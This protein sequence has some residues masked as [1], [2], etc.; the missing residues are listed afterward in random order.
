ML[1]EEVKENET[2]VETPEAMAPAPAKEETP[3]VESAPKV[4]KALKTEEV[5]PKA[6]PK[7]ET[8][9]TETAPKEAAPK[10]EHEHAPR[11]EGSHGPRHEGQGHGEA[12]A[13]GTAPE[14][15]PRG[16][17]HH[18]GAP[19]RDQK[20]SEE[21]K[22]FEERTVYI[23]RVAKTVKG[24][25]RMKFTALVVIGNHKGKYG[26]G[27]GKAAEVPDAIK[28]ATESAKKNIHTIPMVKGGTIP[29]EIT[30]HF[31]ASKVY[32]KPAPEG[33]GIIAGG[34][35]RAVLEL[36]GITN[37]CSK[38]YG[39][40]NSINVVKACD[41]GIQHLT[42]YKQVKKLRVHTIETSANEPAPEVS[43][44]AESKSAPKS[45]PKK[46]TE[47]GK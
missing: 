1:E 27:L 23:N 30:G 43:E 11:P 10:T 15:K 25:R 9:K 35:V 33:T 37:V 20:R 45:A 18:K 6:E 44:E 17:A 36:S 47:G 41:D 7:A 4:P 28:K 40:K 26:Y 38:V 21:P 2:K 34:A 3:K 16:D 32:L 22:E 46:T 31:G 29:H 42:S 19:R 13:E 8:P 12:R 14:R 5:A 39:S 24:G